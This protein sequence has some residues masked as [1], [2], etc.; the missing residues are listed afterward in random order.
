M[1]TPLRVLILEDQPDDAQLMLAELRLAG[2]EPNWKRVQ[3]EAEY[4]AQIPLDLDVILADYHLPTFD[5]LSALHLLQERGRDLPF[6]VVTGATSEEVAVECM[7]HGAADYLLKDRLGRLGPAVKRALEQK[8]LRDEKRLA[9]EELRQSEERFSKAFRASPVAIGISTLAEG[10]LLDVNAS[11]LRLLGYRRSEVIGRSINDLDIWAD[12]DDR[13]RMLSA[14]HAKR[15]VHDAESRLRTKSGEIRTGLVSAE[16][17][18]LGGERCILALIQ[19]ITERKQAEEEIRRQTVRAQ[20]L[21]RVA[22]RLN[23]QLDLDA[24]LRAVCEETAQALHVPIATVSLYDEQRDELCYTGGFGVPP[25]YRQRAQPWTRTAYEVHAT[26]HSPVGVIPDVRLISGLP[27]VE[28]YTA[29]DVC[30]LAL[31]SL[32]R[33]GRLVGSLNV[34]TSGQVRHFSED[35]LALLKGLADQAAV[36]IVNARQHESLQRRLQESEAMASIS[37]ALNETLD[38]ERIFQMIVDAAR[39]I[40]PKVERAVIHLLDEERQALRPVAV[41][42]MSAA[43][44]SEFS[45]RPGEGIAGQVIATGLVVNVGD[46]QTDPRYLPLGRATHL[47]SMLVAPV[48]SGA[49]PLGTIS[50]QS[51]IPA[52]FSAD[53]ERLLATLGVQAAL[54]ITN[55]RLYAHLEKS[56]RQ[57]KAARVQMVQTEKLAA[58]GRLVASVAHELNNPLQAIQ[59]ALYLVKQEQTLVGQAREDLQVA[60]TETDRMA[61]LIN[62]LRETYRPTTAEQFHLE[63][64]NAIVLDV[65]RL[66]GTHL[67]HN[68]IQFELDPDPELPL[69]PAIR[70]QLKQVILNL[71]LNA[72]EAMPQG[73]QLSVRTRYLPGLSQVL[74]SVSDSGTGI[75]PAALPNIFDPFF[76]TKEGGTGLGLAISYDIVQRHNGRME[77]DSAPGRGTAFQIWFPLDKTEAAGQNARSDD[78]G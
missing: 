62:R 29:L 23:A 53:D 9:E 33:E 28:I 57:E 69:I 13:A 73:G 11:F 30:S 35:E 59:N 25:D 42:G 39:Q 48:V 38:A 44:Q 18:D 36:A 78:R 46:I 2:F 61:E 76:T 22:A 21:V 32:L 50:V 14:L 52:A 67:R 17:I 58:M 34:A 65:Q 20:A 4:L 7:K 49:R 10:R 63:P 15:S 72:V 43:G 56:L 45:M 24:V 1:P 37:R 6:I 19:D 27:D 75:D 51:P 74:V 41:A 5:A 68:N 66:I 54:A 55:A 47:R 8:R 60:L 31:A 64:L 16:L 70:D 3:T 71:C 77:V 40:I 26:P 12:A